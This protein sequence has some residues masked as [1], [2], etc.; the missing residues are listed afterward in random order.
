MKK[1]IVTLMLA[2]ALTAS[3][4][5]ACG[6]SSDSSTSSSASASSATVE[7]SDSSVAETASSSVITDI[8]TISDSTAT[9]NIS[10]ESVSV[11]SES[12]E[13]SVAF[14]PIG[15]SLAIDFYLNGPLE[16]PDDATGKWRKVTFS[17]GEVEFQYYALCYYDTYFESDDEV[18]VLYN[19]SNK[20]VNC[21]NCF[22]S[23]LDLRVLDYVDKEEHSAKAACGGTLLAEYHI[24]IAT[25]V[26]EQ[27]Q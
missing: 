1:K 3:A 23:F 24:D 22:G 8:S 5:T 21:I 7:S 20:T 16:F 27:I 2:T 17:E 9:E 26:V 18:H 11:S 13:D 6:S 10:E 14:T 15:D 4:L 12:S 25:G 19:F